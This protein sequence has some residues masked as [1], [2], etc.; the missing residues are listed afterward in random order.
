MSY[1]EH[2][3]CDADYQK[4]ETEIKQLQTELDDAKKEIEQLKKILLIHGGHSKHCNSRKYPMDPFK[5]ND[6]NCG[7]RKILR[8]AGEI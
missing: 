6:C 4:H 8:K 7:W 2:I 3:E 5:L 1:D